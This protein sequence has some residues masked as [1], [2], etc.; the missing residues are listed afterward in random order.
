[1]KALEVTAAVH[2]V[3]SKLAAHEVIVPMIGELDVGMLVAG[4]YG[5]SKTAEFIF[6]STT[7]KLIKESPVPVLMF[8]S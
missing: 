6:G 7:Q 5:S 4:A 1:M 2:P 8:H 3:D